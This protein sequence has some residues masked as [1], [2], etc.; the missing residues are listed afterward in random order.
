MGCACINCTIAEIISQYVSSDHHDWDQF[1]P[2]A[3]FAYD[4]SLHKTTGYSPFVLFYGHKPTLAIN[5][6]LH[7]SPVQTLAACSKEL[8]RR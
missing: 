3:M 5:A 1:L 4:S 2:F 6:D 7:A 8:L